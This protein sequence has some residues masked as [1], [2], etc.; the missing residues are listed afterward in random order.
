MGTE[1]AFTPLEKGGNPMRENV[2]RSWVCAAALLLAATTADRARGD[3]SVS[4]K[5]QTADQLLAGRVV[6]PAGKPIPGVR[7]WTWQ[8]DEDER[9]G[10]E[11][12]P[13]AITGP[14]GTFRIPHIQP[15]PFLAACPPGWLYA[16][17]QV[18][19]SGPFP[20]LELRLQPGLRAAGRVVDASGKPVAGVLLWAKHEGRGGGGCVRITVP[21]PC[22]YPDQGISTSTDA[23]GRYVFESLKPGWVEVSVSAEAEH[24]RL[25]RR[26]EPGG[27]I[28]GLDFVLTR[29]RVS[30]EG[31]VLDPEGDPLAGAAVTLET[32]LPE[33]ETVT[34][35]EGVF[36]FAQVLSGTSRLEVSHPDHGWIRQDVEIEERPLHLDL[37]MPRGTLLQG[38][39]LGPEGAPVEQVFL[40]FGKDYAD[41]APDGSFRL[42]VPPG[43]YEISGTCFRPSGKVRRRLTVTGREEGIDLDLRL[44][45]PGTV[46][47]RLTGL[48][49]GDPGKIDLK[50]R[51]E[52]DGLSF[53]T[54]DG[55]HEIDKVLAGTWTLVASDGNGRVFERRFEIAEGE[56]VTL[57][58][59]DFPPLPAVRGRVLDPAGQSVAQAQV[60]FRQGNREIQAETDA[61]GRFVTWLRD[62][63]WTLRAERDG[64]GPAIAAAELSSGTPVELPDLRLSRLVTAS[65]RLVGV[66]PEVVVPQVQAREGDAATGPWATME[67]GNRFHFPGLWP[68]TWTLTADVDGQEVSTTFV[69]QPGDT[70]V[71]VDLSA[72]EGAP[73]K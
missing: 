22:G 59:I 12:R 68:G 28:A 19:G 52:E 26:G 1:P 40:S 33:E 30:L 43:E 53:G 49:P 69:I 8:T 11:P 45:R 38:R 36:R 66:A 61:A 27:E 21:P 64:F 29:T 25:R 37:Q 46:R 71:D 54:K 70:A 62:G 17:K 56:T 42:T 20:E 60:T 41:V 72:E 32:V 57:A 24:S 6:D 58:G 18:F 10:S 34:D 67:P 13:L 47:V 39:I 15:F 73:P 44:A 14:D 65:G 23:E 2:C 51:S 5:G 35:E 4:Q 63:S 7:I 48:P 3:E 55:F 31:R 16:G 9:Q 50:D